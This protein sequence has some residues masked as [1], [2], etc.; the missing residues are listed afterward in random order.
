MTE[1]IVITGFGVLTAF[2]QGVDALRH[3]VFGGRPAFAPVTRFDTTP[4]RTDRAACLPGTPGD[5]APRQYDALRTC[6]EDALAMAGEPERGQ[7]PVLLGT[8]GD[9]HG[10]GAYWRAAVRD[11]GAATPARSL[12]TDDHLATVPAWLPHQVAAEFGLGGGHHAYTNACVASANAVL[13]AC[14]LLRS[15]RH[16][17]VVCGGAYLVDE[18]F[19]AK[20]DS[21]RAFSRD[22]TVR[23]FAKGRSGLLLGDGAAA[24][25]LETA[26]AARRRGAVPLARITG[27][28]MAADAHDVARP[29]P[30]GRGMAAALTAAL[31][32]AGHRPDAIDYVNAHGTGTRF[33][34]SAETTAL[35]TAFGEHAR[36]LAVSSTKST[37]GHMWEA[38]GAVELV[39]TLLA[40][41]DQLL[42]P[43]AGL[44]TADPACDLDYVPRTARPARIRGAISLNAGFGGLNSAL[45]LERTV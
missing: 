25:V 11:D 17:A 36:R 13:H 37:T 1:P 3:G 19:F 7:L 44:E 12:P 10:V 33:N 31:R 2:G 28:G 42:P 41:R 43:T 5:R 26:S 22:G 38:T 20:F 34:D 27:W 40:L 14:R 45:L 24:L 15:G 8:Q 16:D 39:I 9:Y 29:H 30:R 6:V 4:F 32:H 21:G 23:P 35:H 18:E